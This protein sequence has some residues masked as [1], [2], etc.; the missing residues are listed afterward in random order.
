[1]LKGFCVCFG[2][3]SSYVQKNDEPDDT[4]RNK[5]EAEPDL[6]LAEKIFCFFTNSKGLPN[7][8][9]LKSY[10]RCF[11][12]L[13]C[14][15]IVFGVVLFLISS[16]PKYRH[17]HTPPE[18]F[19]ILQILTF[20]YFTLEYAPKLLVAGWCRWEILNHT[21]Y[22][23]RA[24][25]QGET[26]VGFEFSKIWKTLIDP[27]LLIDFLATFP[28]WI[29]MMFGSQEGIGSYSIILRLL[30]LVRVARIIQLFAK[31]SRFRKEGALLYK[32]LAKTT[33]Q[34]FRLFVYYS[35]AALVMGT[36]IFFAERGELKTVNGVEGHYVVD[37]TG[38]EV[39]SLFSSILDGAWWFLVTGTSV[40]YG[41]VY[42]QTHLGRTIAMVAILMGLIAVALPIGMIQSQFQILHFEQ[43][44]LEAEAGAAGDRSAL[45]DLKRM[46]DRRDDKLVDKFVSILES[47]GLLV[48]DCNVGLMVKSDE[49]FGIDRMPSSEHM[50]LYGGERFKQILVKFDGLF[51]NFESSSKYSYHDLLQQ[52]QRDFGKNSSSFH[53]QWE[54]E[55]ITCESDF[56]S[57]WEKSEHRD[58]IVF[59]MKF[60]KEDDSTIVAN[61]GAT[62]LV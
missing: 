16:L 44:Q 13:T 60:F 28:F 42:P 20:V 62:E 24:A 15:M 10:A 32:T 52:I 55:T 27:L 43:A 59:E 49:D 22:Y 30:R 40:G 11:D 34:L 48:K 47:R 61:P 17:P 54:E 26:E 37:V 12:F 8:S 31:S 57:C 38:K 29:G 46:L 58:Q 7:E 56:I 5:G 41:D 51:L 36:L 3:S 50:S 1:M 39:Q 25:V 14:F 35:L 6:S 18:S 23:P 33:H 45:G 2:D 19:K 9:R 21:L 4:K 53:L